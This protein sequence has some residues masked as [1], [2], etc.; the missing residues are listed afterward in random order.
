L[1]T[2]QGGTALLGEGHI[3]YWFND[4]F[5][6]QNNYLSK[7]RWG[8][9]AKY[10]TSL[11]DIP[12]DDGAGGTEDVPLQSTEVDLR[13]RFNQGLW[14]RDET[15]GAILAYEALTIGEQK[16]NK[17]GAGLF[18]ARSMPRG[19]DKFLNHV[20]FLNHP[21]YVDMEFIQFFSSTDSGTTMGSDFLVNFHG[22]VMW[23]NNFFGE[24]GF[25]LK[26]YNFT[27]SDETG[28]KLTTFYGTL[29]LGLD[30]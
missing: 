9:S 11:G 24:A 3:Q 26:N 27:N 7:Q 16:A 28:A 30:F 22:K 29:G 4:L 17:I 19:I 2:S 13:Y 8:M 23:T 10:F 1:A 14:G 18:W 6:W 25:G 20:S 21:K 5:G 15:V 12:A